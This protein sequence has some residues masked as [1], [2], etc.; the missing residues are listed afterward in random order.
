MRA[1]PNQT[2]LRLLKS[3]QEDRIADGFLRGFV[4]RKRLSAENNEKPFLTGRDD[5]IRTSDLTHPKP[6]T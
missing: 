1:A 6:A 4:N 2:K 3:R 5:W